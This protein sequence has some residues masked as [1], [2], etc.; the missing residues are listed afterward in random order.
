[1]VMSDTVTVF[2]A[3]RWQGHVHVP[4]GGT[5]SFQTD[6][7]E[8]NQP[9]RSSFSI[10]SLLSGSD[11]PAVKTEESYNLPEQ[12][13]EEFIE[14]DD[15]LIPEFDEEDDETLDDEFIDVGG[16]NDDEIDVSRD[17]EI[18][19][20]S[21]TPD[22]GEKN[23]GTPED[24]SETKVE[25]KKN[26]KPPFSYNALIMMAIR[27]NPEKRLTLNGI[28]EFI[29]T[30][31]PY[32][33]SNKQGWQNSIRHNLSLN[34]CFIK[35]PRHYDDPGKGNYWMLD[36]TCDD[37]FIGG[38]TG[39]L[40]RRS[41]TTSRSRLAAFRRSFGL[42]FPHSYPNFLPGVGPLHPGLLPPHLGLARYGSPLQLPSLPSSN[43]YLN[44][45]MKPGLQLPQI[46]AGEPGGPTV[47]LPRLPG[48][49]SLPFPLRQISPVS[50]TPSSLPSSLF[51]PSLTNSLS[52]YSNFRQ[53]GNPSGLPLSLPSSPNTEGVSPPPSGVKQELVYHQQHSPPSPQNY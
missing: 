47:D 6:K 52:F 15:K 48:L 49:H 3:A 50:S 37:V 35:V 14:E 19:R 21:D 46:P 41:T 42:G 40:R 13:K 36:P 28:Y 20:E 24:G 22:L 51:L 4:S 44:S 2:P 1:M 27:Q 43:P 29:M 11:E 17:S 34:K 12:D 10:R 39:K 31:F 38:T 45:F 16:E 8:E 5:V 18:S 25:K 53:F 7:T 33:K 30:N 23:S 26:E 9:L 32:Y